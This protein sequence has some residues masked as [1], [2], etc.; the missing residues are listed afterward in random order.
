[1]YTVMRRSIC[2]IDD[3]VCWDHEYEYFESEKKAE[4]F[5]KQLEESYSAKAGCLPEHPWYGSKFYVWKLPDN[6]LKSREHQNILWQ[7]ANV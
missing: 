7:T 6:Y 1:M 4:R 5:A 2:G 3:D